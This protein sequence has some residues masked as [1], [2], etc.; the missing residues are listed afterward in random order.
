MYNSCK[1]IFY[2]KKTDFDFSLLCQ[3]TIFDK[4]RCRLINIDCLIR[5]SFFGSFHLL[6][7]DDGLTVVFVVSCA[8]SFQYGCNVFD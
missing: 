2:K 5:A 6:S 7:L 8:Q 4:M 3:G 1:I